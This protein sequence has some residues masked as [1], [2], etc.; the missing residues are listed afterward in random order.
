MYLTGREY[1]FKGRG[2]YCFRINGQV[3]HKISQMKPET[4]KSPGFSQIYIYDQQNEL[5][6]HLQ[7]FA[8]LDRTLLHELQ[9]MIKDMNPYAQKY[10]HVGEVIK[11]KPTEDVHLVLKATRKTVDPQRYNLPNGSDV[12]VVIPSD[13]QH[14]ASHRDVCD[15]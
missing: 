2:P 7:P 9:E 10:K 15:I 4:G 13:S 5:D 11:Q 8:K 3:Y 1:T 6:N 14:G 12:A